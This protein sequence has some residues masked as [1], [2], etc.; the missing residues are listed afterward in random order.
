MHAHPQQALDF[1][2]NRLQH[3]ESDYEWAR[4]RGDSERL[5]RCRMQIDAIVAEREQITKRLSKARKRQ[6]PII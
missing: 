3:V 2:S 4:R 1:L 6:S 5:L